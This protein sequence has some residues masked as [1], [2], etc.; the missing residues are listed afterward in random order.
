[1]LTH[2]IFIFI[3]VFTFAIKYDE[4]VKITPFICCR[5]LLS[6]IILGCLLLPCIF[7]FLCVILVFLCVCL[8]SF[9]LFV[10]L[11]KSCFIRP[12]L[13]MSWTCAVHVLTNFVHT[14]MK[15]SMRHGLLACGDGRNPV[16]WLGVIERLFKQANE[17]CWVSSALLFDVFALAADLAMVIAFVV[18]LACSLGHAT[19]SLLGVSVNNWRHGHPPQKWH[20]G[21][22]S[23]TGNRGQK[24]EDYF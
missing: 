14:L 24:H 7:L 21:W 4:S 10:M 12:S 8:N 1:M 15:F 6:V 2:C 23:Y 17:A 18:F 16:M 5:C 22:E 13:E 9:V 11:S 19:T 3:F 20:L